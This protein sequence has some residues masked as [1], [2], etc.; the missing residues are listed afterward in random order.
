MFLLSHSFFNW[1][2]KSRVPF[3]WNKLFQ[4]NHIASY[5]YQLL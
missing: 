1:N 5:I 3:D 2:V 4:Y